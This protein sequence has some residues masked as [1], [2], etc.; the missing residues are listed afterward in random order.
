MIEFFRASLQEK[1]AKFQKVREGDGGFT[2]AMGVLKEEAMRAATHNE[3]AKTL[4]GR[5]EK[6]CALFK[7]MHP[8]P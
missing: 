1:E 3:A 8:Q 6:G 2:N 7:T 4:C 5:V